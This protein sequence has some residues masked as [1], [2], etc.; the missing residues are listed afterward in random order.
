[1][2]TFTTTKNRV[3]C[4]GQVAYELLFWERDMMGP[5]SKCSVAG[6][7]LLLNLGTTVGPALSFDCDQA[8]KR[9]IPE[10][11]YLI[12]T[13]ACDSTAYCR[14]EDKM[15]FNLIRGIGQKFMFISPD[16]RSD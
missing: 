10:G 12:G 5:L 1:M 6:L 13:R 3:I 15:D 8:L 4:S 14:A 11:L 2:G 7:A 9:K 16:S